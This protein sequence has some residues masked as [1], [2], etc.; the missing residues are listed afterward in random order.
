M[1]HFLLNAMAVADLGSGIVERRPI[2]EEALRSENPALLSE[3]F[4]GA[5]VIAAGSLTGSFAPASG[6]VTVYADGKKSFLTGH[7]G[8]A[9]R[10]CGLDALVIAGKADAPLALLLNEKEGTLRPADSSLD[11]PAAR[12]AL[13][14]AARAAFPSYADADPLPLVTGPAAFRGCRS[15]CL[16]CETGTAP[17]SADSAL[18]FAA[19]N[20]AGIAFCGNAG[21]ASPVPLDDPLRAAVPAQRVSKASLAALLNAAGGCS[22]ADA[23]TPGRSL[24]CHA[25][26]A[27]C[28]FWMSLGSAFVPCTSPE[29]L[30]VLL[31]TGASEKRAAEIL[32]LG[33][34]FGVDAAALALLVEA[35]PLPETLEDCL[36]AA[37]ALPGEQRDADIDAS[38]E[39]YG[40]CAFFLR[41][42]PAASAA[43]RARREAGGN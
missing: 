18:A 17:R 42:F 10:L 4:P 23:V 9:L 1:K 36:S 32:A 37:S 7:T 12:R 16:A 14:R 19:R 5:V 15:S 21:F 25:C 41:R 33:E 13:I 31:N 20:L 22:R 3:L 24:A 11:V 39:E 27:P 6:L 29:A 43:L 28:G 26:P 35:A 34:R 8:R 40:I 2:P 30:A 38:A